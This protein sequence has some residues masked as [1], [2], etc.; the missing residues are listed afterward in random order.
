MDEH[1]PKTT[2]VVVPLLSLVQLFANPWTA[3][4][5]APLSAI[6]QSLLKFVSIESVML[7]NQLILRQLL[8]LLPSI[9]PSIR[10]VSNKWALRI[11]WPQSPEQSRDWNPPAFHIQQ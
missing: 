9:F 3:A 6:S 2:S 1:P 5:Q 7:S 10:V 8:L 4:G 11:W